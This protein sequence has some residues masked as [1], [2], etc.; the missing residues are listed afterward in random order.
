LEPSWVIG[1]VANAAL[2]VAVLEIVMHKQ[3]FFALVGEGKA[4]GKAQ[5][6]GIN[7]NGKAG[8]LAVFVHQQD[9]GRAVQGLALL[10]VG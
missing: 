8:L 7:G 6:V 1:C 5:Y 4:V 9:D 2:N 3:G 10:A